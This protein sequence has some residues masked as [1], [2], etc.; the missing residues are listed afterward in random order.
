M[1][2][3][4]FQP[5]VIAFTS[6]LLS[7]SSL[8]CSKSEKPPIV[9]IDPPPGENTFTNPLLNGAD[10][11]VA[12]KDGV[13]YYLHTTGGNIQIRKTT[14][15]SKLSSALSQTIYTPTSGAAN[16]RN[17]WAPEIHFLEGKW[18]IYYTAGD[19]NDVN[20]RTWVLENSN[21]DPTTGTWVDKGK[22]FNT[23]A[24]FWAIDGSVLQ[25]NNVN[26]FI[27]C[28][29]PDRTNI[30]LTQNIYISRMT[31]P[32]TLEGP[33]T[34]LTTPQLGWERN[35]FGVNEGPQSLK[36]PTG[37]QFLIYSASFCGTDDYALGMLTLKDGGNPMTLADWEKSQQPVFSKNPTG[38]AFGPGHNGFFKSSDGTEDW[39]IYHANSSTGQGCGGSRN[40][41]IQKFTYNSAGV[42][43]FGSPVATGLKVNVPS[44]EK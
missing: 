6:A 8:S 7:L 44:G 32:W 24:D 25:H 29:R 42:P 39:I 21:A 41:R 30:N 12:Q 14:A 35:G 27:W 2:R 43:V 5:A 1:I 4:Y 36:G 40:V 10:P 17:V 3:P 9:P 11:W 37:K 22:I 13:Y 26:Y 38:N 19:G 34:M 18:Y 33:V 20:Q 15:I 16:S 31:N 28:G 23:N